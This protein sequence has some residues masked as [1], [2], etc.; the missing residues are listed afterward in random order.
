MF[1]VVVLVVSIF[2]ERRMSHNTFDGAKGRTGG[3]RFMNSGTLSSWFLMTKNHNRIRCEVSLKFSEPQVVLGE[4]EVPMYDRVSR[5]VVKNKDDEV[6]MTSKKDFIRLSDLQGL[7]NCLYDAK[8]GPPEFETRFFRGYAARDGQAY[9]T[10]YVPGEKENRYMLSEQELRHA[11]VIL[12]G[13]QKTRE[14]VCPF[15]P[16][17]PRRDESSAPAANGTTSSDE[18][19]ETDAPSSEEA[20]TV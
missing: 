6:I 4:R 14:V 17:E 18:G 16:R 8:S 19:D 3:R 2:K 5:E 15:V 10:F 7:V 9:L 11:L 20:A 12:E 1:S 13:M